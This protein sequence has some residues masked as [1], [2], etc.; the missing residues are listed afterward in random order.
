M[1]PGIRSIPGGVM[2]GDVMGTTALILARSAWCCTGNEHPAVRSHD[3]DIHQTTEEVE[4]P[5][6]DLEQGHDE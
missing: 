6:E 3:I 1:G 2:M 5:L 4:G